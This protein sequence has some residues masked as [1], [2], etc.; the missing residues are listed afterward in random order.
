MERCLFRRGPCSPPKGHLGSLSVSCSFLS[1]CG[2]SFN[3]QAY[4]RFCEG[5][6]NSMRNR[7]QQFCF[8]SL[9]SAPVKLIFLPIIAKECS[10]CVCSSGS[11]NS[12][13]HGE[14]PPKLLGATKDFEHHLPC[15]ILDISFSATHYLFLKVSL[16][17][18]LCNTWKR[19]GV[20]SCKL[21]FFLHYHEFF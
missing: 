13:A 17:N 19:R 2:I 6:K 12:Y 10:A 16:L 8:S 14:I 18:L 11:Q 5:R 1:M 9:W 4:Y 21:S 3:A 15:K 7:G 20:L